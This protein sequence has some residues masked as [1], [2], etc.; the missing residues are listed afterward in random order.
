MRKCLI[1]LL[2]TSVAL[3]SG[4]VTGRRSVSLGVPQVTPGA[5]D[6]GAIQITSVA[7]NREFQ[8]NPLDAS[9]PSINGDVST[10][11]PE[12]KSKMIGRQRNGFGKAMGDIALANNESVPQRAQA[13]V[14]A[15]LKKR[16]YKIATD[17]SAPV[18]ASVS[19]DE[20]WAWFTPG[21]WTISFEAKVVCTITL[22]RAG[23]P[24]SVT[25]RGHGMNK[26]QVASDE[27]WQRA[28][29]RAFADF[30]EKFDKELDTTPF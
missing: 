4:C 10:M 19:V 23:S 2:L 24:A 16:G 6:R 1:V 27:N 21:M 29:D 14:E 25:I 7:D 26:G 13:L 22:T 28:Y 15:A 8:N 5:V 30:L 12:Q 11:T 3:L 17:G 18:T 9:V 20:F